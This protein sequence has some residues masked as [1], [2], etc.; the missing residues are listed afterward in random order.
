[1]K[2][3]GCT[4]L[5]IYSLLAA[6]LVRAATLD[7]SLIQTSG[8][9]IVGSGTFYG[10]RQSTPT[11]IGDADGA[12]STASAA[13][14]AEGVPLVVVWSN[15]GCTHCDDFV[16]QLNA[17]PSGVSN[18]L[19]S[20][21][22]IFAFF[23]DNS[24][25]SAPTVGHKPK[26]CYDAWNF[27]AN[28]CGAKPV[29]PLFAFYYKRANGMVVK[30]GTALDRTGATRT[31]AKFKSA[32]EAFIRK[33]DISR[34]HGGAF[35]ATGGTFDR[36]EA[37]P[38]TA[39]V[40]VE[41]VRD[42]DKGA[43]AYQQKLTATWPGEQEARWESN[44]VW[45]VSETAKTVR[46]PLARAPEEPFPVGE[47]TLKLFDALDK[48]KATTPIACLMPTDS[49]ENPLW[50][51]ERDATTLQYGEWTC[52][53][54]TATNKVADA[55]ALGTN[56]WTLV[57][58]HGSQWC[59]YCYLNGP[60]FVLTSAFRDWA[61]QHNVILVSADMPHCSD[62]NPT[63]E[64]GTI[65]NRKA[66]Q[67]NLYFD[68]GGLQWRSGRG[69]LSRKMVS[70]DEARDMRARL[71]DLNVG[72]LHLPED[73]QA[74]RAII[75]GMT[76]LDASG[77]VVGRL[78]TFDYDMNNNTDGQKASL[79][80]RRLTEML[81]AATNAPD[82]ASENLNDNCVTTPLRLSV[83]AKAG[84]KSVGTG[85]ISHADY[86]DIYRLTGVAPGV[87][88]RFTCRG[89]RAAQT[90][91]CLLKGNAA[92]EV[93][94]MVLSVT[95]LLSGTL[96]IDTTEIADFSFEADATYFLRVS[97]HSI[98]PKSSSNYRP[99][100]LR[101]GDG[102]DGFSRDYAADYDGDTLTGY[103]V[104]AEAVCHPEEARRT[105][106]VPDSCVVTLAVEKD[107]IYRLEG[108]DTT[109]L[110]MGLKPDVERGDGFYRATTD[111][112]W[113][114]L[115][116][117]PGGS[118]IAYQVWHPGTVS[119]VQSAQTVYTH[120]G[121][122]TIRV[123]RRDG[124]SGV[125]TERV[126]L[127]DADEFAAGRYVWTD[128]D[129]TWADGED[130]EKAVTLGIV[131]PGDVPHSTGR[132]TFGVGG[133][134]LIV[135]LL[136]TDAPGLSL[137]EYD[138]ATY[139]YFS[140]GLSFGTVNLLTD[141]LCYVRVVSGALPTGTRLV[142]DRETG[143]VRLEGEPLQT[144]TYE[145]GVSLAEIRPTGYVT[146]P[147]SIVRVTVKETSSVNAKL[148]EKRDN[149]ELPLKTS[150]SVIAGTLSV[151]ITS[152]G[153]ISARYR[154][155]EAKSAAFSGSWQRLDE[156]TG[157]A[158]AR[159]ERNDC[160]LDLEMDA[161]GTLSATLEVPSD[162]SYFAE[163][164]QRLTMT[165]VSPWP[166]EASFER[167]RGYYNVAL[168]VVSGL[169]PSP[170]PS[171]TGILSL[172]MT[173]D[174]AASSGRMQYT[175]FLPDGTPVNGTG[176]LRRQGDDVAVLPIFRRTGKN[177]FSAEL[178][179]KADAANVWND[180]DDVT[181]REVVNRTV[182]NVAMTLHRDAAWEY[183]CE[184]DAIGSFYVPRISP[185]ELTRT[186]YASLYGLPVVSC[187]AFGT[188]CAESP[189]FGSL[190]VPSG[191]LG[192]DESTFV[193]T[194]PVKGL[195]FSFNAQTGVFRGSAV[196]T[197]S[198][199]KRVTGSYRGILTP[200]WVKNCN[201]GDS[202]K[203]WPFGSGF[204]RYRDFNAEGRAVNKSI[205]L[206]LDPIKRD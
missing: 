202:P 121:D 10:I 95:N 163:G 35:A 92:G 152:R 18:W 64:T 192:A 93:T 69:Y 103:E 177:V 198:S 148:T 134:G 57:Y 59:P 15:E 48:V 80:C 173:T 110:P 19:K 195:T 75:P 101:W 123:V 86:R 87:A 183:L 5:A 204:L 178:E 126:R 136:D 142:C 107:E 41:L 7:A 85:T 91:L 160:T 171:G 186:F 70:E 54:D 156:D 34:Y 9:P 32:Y 176:Q 189:R 111:E 135:T 167:W 27:A 53:L 104:S 144:G 17:D 170:V 55:R 46:V 65:W 133:S 67:T 164:G 16:R 161:A 196:V 105:V 47:I 117:L 90:R 150:G 42:D 182:G 138:E 191:V 44:L 201:C 187:L 99:Y 38:A 2:S 141:G 143:E 76:L 71:H 140:S 4:L 20:Q 169:Y 62:A 199:G 29:W 108:F 56:A 88:A 68:G 79:F 74:S 113:V 166:G 26:A 119:F 97:G 114:D 109:K 122:A 205:P 25:D 149:V 82:R 33:Y 188:D 23:K 50:L 94:D 6:G 120:M 83:Y 112:G 200:G 118:S 3:S 45:A 190:S 181:A 165:A 158:S 168:P 77:R 98:M 49:P 128:A 8:T 145:F 193:L 174:S 116:A 51:T 43:Y 184:L 106:A 197:F 153:R 78:E 129:V 151:A 73:Y 206:T 21:D 28:T 139:Q 30:E 39:F 52:D 60:S 185:Y 179:V 115:T 96:V 14:L 31:W 180:P 89:S 130:G 159:L 194:E 40:D 175:G 1:M 154:G 61:V 58:S 24:G 172:R 72:F 162:F 63:V 36:Y 12:F 11:V 137:L 13:A 22:A 84:E 155:T 147:A 100:R 127:V 66:E 157:R 124:V 203:L 125:R 37:E 102:D 131:P 132:L 146:G 81:V